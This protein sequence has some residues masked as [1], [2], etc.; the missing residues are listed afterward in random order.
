VIRP[1]TLLFLSAALCCASLAAAEPVQLTFD[2]RIKRWPVFT[3]EDEIVFTMRDTSPI[4]TLQ[5]LKISDGSI[6]RLHPNATLPET[7]ATFSADGKTYAYLELT[8]ND[9]VAVHVADVAQTMNDVLHF[10]KPIPWDP[11]I[12]PDG[13]GVV[14]SLDGQLSWQKP[15]DDVEKPL[16]KSAGINNWPSVSPDGRTIVF[17]SSRGGSYD[18]YLIGIDGTGERRLTE[19]PSLDAHPCWSPDGKEIAFTSTRDGNYEIY[20]MRGDGSNVRRVTH[21]DERDDFPAWHPNGRKLAV[22][23]ERRGRHDLFLIEVPD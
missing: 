16:T 10:G 6:T 12:A 17:S 2:G 9:A 18:L 4:L 3:S 22:V 20:V 8:G 11:V 5:R 14:V 1:L 7:N 23:S 15:G 13:R 21:H 19:S